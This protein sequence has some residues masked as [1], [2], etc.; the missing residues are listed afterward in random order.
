[1]LRPTSNYA[2]DPVAKIPEYKVSAINAV[3]AVLDRATRDNAFLAQLA[4]NPAEALKDY[5]LTAEEKA[6]LVSG[7]LRKIESGWAS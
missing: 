5:K 2:L 1:L 3:L 7:D 4:E 6:A